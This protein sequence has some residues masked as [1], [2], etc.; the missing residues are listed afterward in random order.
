MLES[1][2][3]EYLRRFQKKQ[4]S[5]PSQCQLCKQAGC[6]RW[7]GSYVRRLIALAKTHSVPIRRLFCTLCGHTFAL[8]PSF[9]AKFHRYAKDVIRTALAWLKILTYDAVAERL[10]ND[11]LAR[12]DRGVATLT[13]YFWRRKFGGLRH[14]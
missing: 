3:D 13:V 2:V 1:Q 12:E 10:A 14:F 5:K 9:I 11:H 7:H 4:L 6:L 8:L